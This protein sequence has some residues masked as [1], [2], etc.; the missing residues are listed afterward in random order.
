MHALSRR[1]RR[2]AACAT[3]CAPR[4]VARFGPAA[5]RGRGLRAGGPGRVLPSHRRRL[6]RPRPAPRPGAGDGSR[7]ASGGS[8]ARPRNRGIWTADKTRKLEVPGPHIVEDELWYAANDALV[9]WGRRG[10]RRTKHVYLLE[11]GLAVCSVCGA[12]IGIAAAS[13]TGRRQASRATYVCSHRRRPPIGGERLHPAA[14]PGGRGQRAGLEG[15]PGA[16]GA[17]GPARRSR[18]GRASRADGRR[19]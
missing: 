10:L 18:D 16:L 6:R 13:R 19:P 5:D 14:P 1:T 8:P 4:L 7:S 15:V 12:R 17:A 9:R 11:T 3:A 2:G